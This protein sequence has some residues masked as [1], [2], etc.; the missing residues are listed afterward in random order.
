MYSFM[1]LDIDLK[2][3]NCDCVISSKR[4]TEDT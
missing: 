2:V 4:E 3:P 1:H